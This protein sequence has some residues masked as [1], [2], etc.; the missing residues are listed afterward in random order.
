MIHSPVFSRLLTLALGACLSLSAI[1]AQP[2]G[3]SDQ[4]YV[5]SFQAVI[6]LTFDELGRAF[7]WEKDGR[8]YAVDDG[9]TTPQPILDLRSEVGGWRDFGMLS[10]A[11]DPDFLT[12]GYFYL[13]YTVDHEHLYQGNPTQEVFA[14]AF[15]RITRYQITNPQASIDLLNVDPLS[16]TVL[17]GE[18]PDLGFPST[19][20]SHHVGSLV[21]GTDGTLLA[22]CGDGASYNTVDEGGPIS[23]GW[24]SEALAAGIISADE[25]IG[26]YRSQYDHS[27][28][29][30]IIRL[31]PMTGDGLPSNPHYDSL[32]SRSVPSRLWARGLRNPCRMI[33][34]PGSGSLDPADG[35]PGV[36]MIGDVGW[37]KREELNIC[38]GPDQNFG[39]PWYEGISLEGNYQDPLWQPGTNGLPAHTPPVFDW[40]NGRTARV[41]HSGTTYDMGAAGNPVVG[42]SFTGNCSM[43]GAWY[44]DSVYPEAYRDSYFH[45]DYGTGWIRH[46]R[47]DPNLEPLSVE[48]FIFNGGD[49]TAL[50][51]NPADGNLYYVNGSTV[52][53]RVIY[54]P[55]NQPPKAVAIADQTVGT[56]SLTVS[57]RGNRSSDADGDSLSYLWDFDDGSTST[58][59]NPSHTF[60]APSGT[61]QSFAVKLTVSDTGSSSV[62]SLIISLNNTPPI[63]HSTSIDDVAVYLN[64]TTL[65][66]SAVVNDAED[67]PGALTYQ[68]QTFLHHDNHNH[69]EAPVVGPTTQAV[70]T[71]IGCDGVLYF[72]RIRLT[73]TDSDGL[74][75]VV[76]RDI[77]PDCAGA[78][79]PSARFQV[80]Q[81]TPLPPAYRLDGSG[82]YD[83]DGPLLSYQWDLGDGTTASG[84]VV[85]HSYFEPGAYSVTL[86]VTD[87]DG[88]TDLATGIIPVS[89][90]AEGTLPARGS[91]GYEKWSGVSGTNLSTIDF[92]NDLPD[93]VDR[94][95]EL[96][97]AVNIDDNYGVRLRGYLHAPQTGIYTIDFT[98][99]DEGELYLSTDDNPAN[100][101]LITSVP[102]WAASTQWDK[103]ATQSA[104]LTLE[105]GRRYYLEGRMKEGGGGDHLI[106]R[107]ELPDGTMQS[108]IPGSSL[109]PWNGGPYPNLW[110]EDFQLPHGLTQDL[111][112]T[113]WALD[114]SNAGGSAVV[115][116]DNG[117]L[118]ATD[119]D[120]EVVWRSEP[121]AIDQ[122]T[123]VNVQMDLRSQ[124]SVD[125]V[126]YLRAYYQLDG[127]SEV[128]IADR[129]G[130]FNNDQWES[131]SVSSV[132][133]DTLRVI[134]RTF[135]T[136]NDE[137]YQV[138][139]VSV[140]SN[141]PLNQAGTPCVR[142]ATGP[143]AVTALRGQHGACVSD[144]VNA[145][146]E[147]QDEYDEALISLHDQNQPLGRVTVE[148][149]DHGEAPFPY[150][151]HYYLH[152]SFRIETELA[153]TS[154]VSL[155]LYLLPAEWA[156]LAAVDPTVSTLQ[157]LVLAKYQGGSLGEVGVGSEQLLSPTAVGLGQ[158]PD[159]SHWVEFSVNDFS[160]FFLR[161]SEVSFPVQWLAFTAKSQ[162]DDAILDWSALA[163]GWGSHFLIQRSLDGEQFT[164][165]E[166]IPM[167]PGV[168]GE[169]SQAY[170]DRGAGQIGPLKLYYRLA[171]V[172]LDGAMI[173]SP[174]RSVRWLRAGLSVLEVFPNPAQHEVTLR[175]GLEQAGPVTMLVIDQ[176]GREVHRQTLSEPRGMHSHQLSVDG[177]GQGIYWIQVI[178]TQDRRQ[179]RFQVK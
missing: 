140:T 163:D 4:V 64:D 85:N 8:I 125:P 17:V 158:G 68:W 154:P 45:A 106:V 36:L 177:W 115:A 23:G 53:R 71:P 13:L 14:Q 83:L 171:Q 57:F 81:Q 5:S 22:A 82:S 167:Q 16:R 31:D 126:D 32:N 21:F 119:T 88:N 157:D 50:A 61:P 56:H 65:N 107:W 164:T 131:V 109:S 46:F 99:D 9:L 91:I 95:T 79:P 146:L 1:W 129:S 133:G 29:G 90:D 59:I 73:V 117:Y 24:I 111:G 28:N 102:G 38:D 19:H 25:N 162:G 108:P 34:Q 175:Y 87:Q 6:G 169:I 72:F 66:L 3:F 10:M 178:T 151:S 141:G 179:Q 134:V 76:E 93:E 40:R 135:L 144:Q 77:Y 165:I 12:N 96:A 139:N 18:T 132:S 166:R 44:T 156:A 155:R 137:A 130:N 110:T 161:G 116:V 89:C 103:Y 128:L 67:P 97:T 123:S 172:D 113:R 60:T 78:S 120:G 35:N 62:D 114:L 11:L 94:R 160:T 42:S 104:T 33:L 176:L 92:D 58:A 49:V 118:Q 173:Y 30:K 124:N 145:W 15:G 84:P 122:E 121:I 2:Q 37:N 26:A 75:T 148:T 147:I 143:A 86:T 20:Q 100:L 74:S 168:R 136:A 27:L 47:F 142:C 127:G 138:D 63:I 48:P 39:W 112:A 51:V 101:A 152:R 70:L 159:G 153:P 52:I 69:P 41:R 150:Q 55:D 149:F 7:V 170:L 54:T 98:S 43:G 174:L 105:A 80:S